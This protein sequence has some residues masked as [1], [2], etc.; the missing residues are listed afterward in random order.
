MKGDWLVG[1]NREC[2]AFQYTEDSKLSVKSMF[3][4]EDAN[5]F[6]TPH[7][8]TIKFWGK[9]E[10]PDAPHESRATLQWKCT[11]QS[12]GFTCFALN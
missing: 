6:E 10:R 5:A 11:R 1:E 12:D 7:N 2:Q 8:L 4:P 9:V 3:C